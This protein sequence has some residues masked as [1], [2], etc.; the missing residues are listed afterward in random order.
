MLSLDYRLQLQ[1]ELQ[2]KQDAPKLYRGVFHGVRVVAQNEGPKG[3][4]RGI[5][6]AVSRQ[7]CA[8]FTE[9]EL[10]FSTRIK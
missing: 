6:S 8:R 7:S 4:F 9:A 1:G 2:A 10:Y 3:L 5:G